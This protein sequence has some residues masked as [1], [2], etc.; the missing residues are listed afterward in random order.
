MIVGIRFASHRAMVS[1][2]NIGP[3]VVRVELTAV[4]PSGPYRLVVEHPTNTL[5]EYFDSALA[6]L[7]R[8]AQIEGTLTGGPLASEI[9]A[10]FLPVSH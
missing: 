3:D 2:F 10:P 7:W 1:F 4:T 9:A 8:Q 6:A 5:I